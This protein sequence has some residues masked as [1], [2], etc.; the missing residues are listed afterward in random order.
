MYCSIFPAF[1]DAGQPGGV[2]KDVEPPLHATQPLW[3]HPRADLSPQPG[4]A[5]HGLRG[6]H[7]EAVEPQQG[8]AL[9]EVRKQTCHCPGPPPSGRKIVVSRYCPAFYFPFVPDLTT[10]VPNCYFFS[11]FIIIVDSLKRNCLTLV[12]LVTSCLFLPLTPHIFH[13]WIL[14]QIVFVDW[15]SYPTY[16][17]ILHLYFYTS[18]RT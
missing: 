1:P 7:P 18:N 11:I 3:R 10:I 17:F 15:I 13:M 5:A 9:Q 4:G 16:I 14:C 2:Q 12:C 8:H 6:R